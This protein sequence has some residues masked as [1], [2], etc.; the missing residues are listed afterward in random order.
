MK[1]FF[2]ISLIVLCAFLGAYFFF[3]SV[4]KSP[5]YTKENCPFCDQEVIGRQRIFED[6]LSIALCTHKPVT[7]GHVLIIPR[8]YV[9]RFDQ[10][11]EEEILS[12]GRTIQKI[13]Q[14]SIKAFNTSAYLLVQKNGRSVGQDVSHL[15][16]HYIPRPA[17]DESQFSFFWKVFTRSFQSPEPQ[18]N[19]NETIRKMKEASE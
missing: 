19:L 6:P 17:G 15:H 18:E 7:P 8:R 4:A 3:F 14:A 12:I 11:T 13:H 16:V 10:L 1:K 2:V 5:S 9:E